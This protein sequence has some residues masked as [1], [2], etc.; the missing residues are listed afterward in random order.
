MVDTLELV[1]TICAT[2]IA[3]AY[4]ACVFIVLYKLLFK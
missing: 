3:L 1:R 4:M 2:L